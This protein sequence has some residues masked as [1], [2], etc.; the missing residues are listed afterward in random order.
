[1][2]VKMEVRSIWLHGVILYLKQVNHNDKDCIQHE[3]AEDHLVP[4][5]NESSRLLFLLFNILQ[6]GLK[7]FLNQVL[8]EL[9]LKWKHF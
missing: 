6:Q 4:E 9:D 7:V 8:P 2:H 1:M 5:L 3:E